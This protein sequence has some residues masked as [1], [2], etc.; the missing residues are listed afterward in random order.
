[1]RPDRL[2]RL[3]RRGADL[4]SELPRGIPAAPHTSVAEAL[5]PVQRSTAPVAAALALLAGLG[6]V[7]TDDPRAALLPGVPALLLGGLW[8]I[9]RQPRRRRVAQVLVTSVCG[10][11][12]L[13]TAPALAG[14][15][16]DAGAAAYQLSCLGL[17]I[18]QL[19]IAWPCWRRAN[20]E[21]ASARAA[22]SLYDEL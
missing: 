19:T 6:P 2:E 15:G 17:A 21:F 5:G 3:R 12:L 22:R 4:P 16:S 13:A 14:L 10:L 9:G 11:L 18:V 7:W 8:W 20:A 1:M